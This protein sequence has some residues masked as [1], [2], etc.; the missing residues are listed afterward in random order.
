MTVL[1]PEAALISP[2]V[3]G[4][5]PHTGEIYAA[6]SGG[7]YLRSPD[8]VLWNVIDRP[9]KMNCF[10]LCLVNSGG[11]FPEL[12]RGDRYIY[13]EQSLTFSSLKL[14]A[15][16]REGKDWLAGP[17]LFP[18]RFSAPE[19]VRRS[20]NIESTIGS[21]TGF[22]S[23]CLEPLQAVWTERRAALLRAVIRR[24]F[25]E[26]VPAVYRLIGFGPGLT[27]A[28]DDFLCGFSLAFY[29]LSHLTGYNRD[30]VHCWQSL[31]D[32]EAANRT[33]IFSAQL[34]N[35]AARG[36]SFWEVRSLLETVFYGDELKHVPARI[37]N[38]LTIG[39][40]T[41]ASTL[42]G[43]R[44]GFFAFRKTLPVS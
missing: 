31:I 37:K 36:E 38:I 23:A 18:E 20:E 22:P 2:L 30:W 5:P 29:Y 11:F 41:G 9:A 39:S 13:Q 19:W 1:K 8:G 4:L 26:T 21:L 6:F 27:P 10:G 44:S 17:S 16:L 28:G 42:E 40:S 15:D 34:L 24:N 32:R 3:Q 12:V 25:A 33:N 14:I 43:L 7:I 35:L